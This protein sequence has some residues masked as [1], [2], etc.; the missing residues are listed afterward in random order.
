MF[1][2]LHLGKKKLKFLELLVNHDYFE[3]R[4]LMKSDNYDPSFKFDAVGEVQ[5]KGKLKP[6]KLWLLSRKMK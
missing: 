2:N 3:F 5:V 6:I 4:Y 1:L